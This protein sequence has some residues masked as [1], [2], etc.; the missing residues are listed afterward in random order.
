MFISSTPTKGMKELFS[1]SIV[2]FT[3]EWQL[4]RVSKKLSAEV[5]FG[6]TYISTIKIGQL[7]ILIVFFFDGAHEYVC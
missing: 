5:L 6:I 7:A 1:T 4:W 2:N 3:E